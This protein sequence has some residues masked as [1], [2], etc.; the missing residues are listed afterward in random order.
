MSWNEMVEFYN[1]L[2]TNV[3]CGDGQLT[4]D[5]LRAPPHPDDVL[6]DREVVGSP[7][8][9]GSIHETDNYDENNNSDDRWYLLTI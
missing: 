9:L 4:D 5:A 7:Y 8:P 6:R 3:E 2:K 1:Q